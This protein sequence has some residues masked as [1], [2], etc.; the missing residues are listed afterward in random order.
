M[1]A[2]AALAAPQPVVTGSYLVVEDAA[3]LAGAR[4]LSTSLYVLP[5]RLRSGHPQALISTLS[6]AADGGFALVIDED[7]VLSLRWGRASGQVGTLAS[8][9][10]L[11]PG[12]WHVISAAL[13]EAD[14]RATLAHAPV[15]AVPGGLARWTGS[16]RDAGLRLASA[17]AV[18]IGAGALPGAPRASRL[19]GAPGVATGFNGR[20]EQPVLAGRAVP[21]A[22]VPALTPARAAAGA[23][24]IGAWDFSRGQDTDRVTD[25]SGHERHGLL[26]NRPARAVTGV[27]WRQDVHDWTR[28]PEQYG[29]STFT[30]TTWTTAGGRRS[31]RWRCRRTCRPACTGSRSRNRAAGPTSSR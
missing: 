4:A 13:D 12:Y 3:P 20:I 15:A 25:A 14:G 29:R 31:P 28:A 11:L 26:V 16:A 23:A 2:V 9:A 1:P 7:G 8:P 5:T 10:G 27:A 19:P 6:P 22:E 18:L 21:A 30:T 24:V 17:P